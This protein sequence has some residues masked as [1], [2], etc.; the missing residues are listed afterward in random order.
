M[1]QVPS[2]CAKLEDSL[3]DIAKP[4]A[5]DAAPVTRRCRVRGHVEGITVH[6]SS[7][8]VQVHSVGCELGRSRRRF[9]GISAVAP[10]LAA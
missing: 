7:Q 3:C 8:C 9:F 4:V 2:A 1:V 6:G 5:R 10:R